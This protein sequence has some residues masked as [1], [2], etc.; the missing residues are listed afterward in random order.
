MLVIISLS[1]KLLVKSIPYLS[2][3]KLVCHTVEQ[4]DDK[5]YC[6]AVVNGKIKLVPMKYLQI[7]DNSPTRTASAADIPGTAAVGS[8]TANL[9]TRIHPQPFTSNRHYQSA[10]GNIRP[11]RDSLSQTFPSSRPAAIHRARSASPMR[12]NTSAPSALPTQSTVSNGHIT[13]SSVEPKLLRKPR[14]PVDL[15]VEIVAGR[16]LYVEWKYISFLDYS[17][18]SNGT[19]VTGFRVSH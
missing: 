15:S 17:A 8:S 10:E 18:R 7:S 2:M 14:A 9:K 6:R 19:T 3:N 4:A 12:L 1:R 5:G 16:K 13:K 11:V